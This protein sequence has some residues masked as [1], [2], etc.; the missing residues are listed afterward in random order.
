MSAVGSRSL[1]G[2]QDSFRKCGESVMRLRGAPCGCCENT[3]LWDVE[4]IFMWLLE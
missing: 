2:R 4:T 3:L 1:L